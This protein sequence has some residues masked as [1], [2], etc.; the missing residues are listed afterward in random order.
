MKINNNS[1]Y[2]QQATTSSYFD[3]TCPECTAD[4][5]RNDTPL[6]ILNIKPHFELLVPII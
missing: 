3:D 5:N 6:A 2:H 4:R 1:K